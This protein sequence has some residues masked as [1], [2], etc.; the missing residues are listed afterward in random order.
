MAKENTHDE[1]E[2]LKHFIE[3]VTAII[4]SLAT[5]ASAWCA[6]QATLRGG[7]QT[8]RLSAV[9]ALGRKSSEQT[10]RAGQMRTIDGL[11]FIEYLKAKHRHKDFFADFFYQRFRPEAKQAIDAWLATKPFQNPQ[12]PPHPFIMEEYS[13]EPEQEAKRLSE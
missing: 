7:I 10:V 11:L 1:K 12:A 3:L 5:I 6:Y 13:L 2:R 8:F 9:N 4:I